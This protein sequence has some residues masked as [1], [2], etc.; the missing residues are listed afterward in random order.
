MLSDEKILVTGPAGQIAFPLAES[1]ARDN[2]VWGIARFGNPAT[3]DEVE[4][5]GVTTRTGDLGGGDFGDLPDDF[6]YV[7][8]LAALMAPDKDYDEAI[9]VERGGHRAAPRALPQGEGRA[10]DVDAVGVPPARG[11]RARVPR[12]RPARRRALAALAA[13]LDLEDRP[14]SRGAVLRARVRPSGDHRPHE[15]VVQRARRAAHAAPRAR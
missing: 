4:A 5:A 11:P 12:D 15:L 9:R 3:R 2:E 10:R 8:H 6:T 14:G 1:L 13:V 7:L